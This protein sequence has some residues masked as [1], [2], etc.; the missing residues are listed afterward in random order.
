MYWDQLKKLPE[1]DTLIDIGV[2]DIGTPMLY[3]RFPNQKLILVDPLDELGVLYPYVL[4]GLD[5]GAQL[6]HKD[7][8]ARLR[9]ALLE[10]ESERLQIIKVVPAGGKG[11]AR[12]RAVGREA[13]QKVRPIRV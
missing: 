7:H 1:I 12:R 6:L 10:A 2:G 5:G 13:H 11:R 8:Q 3:E 9:V 4:L